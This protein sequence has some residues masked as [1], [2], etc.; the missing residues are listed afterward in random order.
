MGENAMTVSFILNGEDVKVKT[1]SGERL[2]TILREQFH[3]LGAKSSCRN[4]FCGVC[5]VIFNGFTVPSCLVPAFKLQNGE[6][7]TIEGL[8]QNDDF[9]DI[10]GGFEE[11]GVSMCGYCDSAKLLTTAS[12]LDK[13]LVPSRQDILA[14]FTGIKCR[15]TEPESLIRGVLAAAA[16]RKERR[17][18]K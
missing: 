7:I 13:T 1:P 11:A 16:K 8:A 15:C 10:T 17:N 18:G 6:V 12:L 9:A 5:T 2:I 3:L 14:A 4:G